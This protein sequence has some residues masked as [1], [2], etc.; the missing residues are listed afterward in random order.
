[1][2]SARAIATLPPMTQEAKAGA[3]RSQGV[4]PSEQ[5]RTAVAGVYQAKGERVTVE[6]LGASRPSIARVIAGLP[7]RRGTLALERFPDGYATA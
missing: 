4:T 2:T 7:V 5:L 3:T 1:L 6:V